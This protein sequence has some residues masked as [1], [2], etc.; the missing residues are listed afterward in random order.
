[1]FHLLKAGNAPMI[2]FDCIINWV[3]RYEDGIIQHGTNQLVMP[4]EI[5]F[6]RF[7]YKFIYKTN[8]NE[9][10]CSKNISNI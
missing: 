9:A 4:R 3:Q 1:M 2:I 7:K 8:S 10:K 5:F 6:T